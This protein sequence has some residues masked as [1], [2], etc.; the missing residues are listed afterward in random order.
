MNE[1]LAINIGFYEKCIFSV[2]PKPMKTAALEAI[3]RAAEDKWQDRLVTWNALLEWVAQGCPELIGKSLT[4]SEAADSPSENAIDLVNR[5]FLQTTGQISTENTQWVIRGY[6]GT[7]SVLEHR[8]SSRDLGAGGIPELLRRLVCNDLTANEII[9]AT[10]GSAQHLDLS[11][12][13]QG[14]TTNGD[15]HYSATAVRIEA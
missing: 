1:D 3:R 10:T 9:S 8:V 7:H 2:S 5:V 6:N 12:T 4:F 14:G 13:A 15:P 11:N